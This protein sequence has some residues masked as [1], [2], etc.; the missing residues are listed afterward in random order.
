MCDSVIFT[1]SKKIQKAINKKS[2]KLT[3]FQYSYFI[4]TYT[5]TQYTHNIV[6]KVNI[7]RIY[8]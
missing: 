7:V 1:K 6:N 5:Y 4:N 3:M 8:M 2:R